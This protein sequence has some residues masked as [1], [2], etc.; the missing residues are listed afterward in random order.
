MTNQEWIKAQYFG[1]EIEMTGIKREVA[2]KAVANFFGTKAKFK[3]GVYGKWI[4]KDG[5]DRIWSMVSDR[6]IRAEKRGLGLTLYENKKDYQVELVTPKLSYTDIPVLQEVIRILRRAGCKVNDSCGIHIHIDANNHSARSLRNLVNIMTSKEDILYRA[7][8]VHDNRLY[9]CKKV[10]E[11]LV[12]KLNKKKPVDLAIFADIWYEGSKEPRTYHYN[13]TRYAGLNLHNV[14]SRGTVEFRLFNSTLHAGEVKSYIQLCLA[15][16]A[17]AITQK[18]ATPAKTKTGNEKFTFRTWLLR[19][20]LIG[21]EFKTA[22][23][24]LLKHLEG[25]AAWRYG[26]PE[27]VGH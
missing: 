5:Q 18:R 22:R 26:Q 13:K 15:I 8:K 14:W 17:Q 21:D 7:L 6:S 16:S 3:G 1:V 24:H 27:A 19:L 23:K 11:A 4:I 25:N 12:E 10:K 9:Y 20:G 2:A